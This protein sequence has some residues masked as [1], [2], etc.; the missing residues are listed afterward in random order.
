MIVSQLPGRAESPRVDVTSAQ[1]PH[2]PSI[3]PHSITSSVDN[4]HLRH[5]SPSIKH[6]SALANETNCPCNVTPNCGPN[7]HACHRALNKGH[8]IAISSPDDFVTPW[9]YLQRTSHLRTTKDCR[10]T[11]L[12]E[13]STYQQRPAE[14]N[15][16]C[17]TVQPTTG[18]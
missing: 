14:N 4:S 9:N 16:A 11:R 3:Y 17:T 12:V 5:N 13:T 2:R 10:P 18:H 7:T 15:R 1:P 6:P 8:N